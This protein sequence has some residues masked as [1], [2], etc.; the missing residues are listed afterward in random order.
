MREER[1]GRV[2]L[3][4]LLMASLWPELADVIYVQSSL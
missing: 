1:T 4:L 2:F 3:E